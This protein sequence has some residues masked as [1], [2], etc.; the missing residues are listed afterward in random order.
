MSRNR[1]IALA[2]RE[3][4]R[5]AP[6]WAPR[7]RDPRVNMLALAFVFSFAAGC[8]IGLMLMEWALS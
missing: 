5:S 7:R 6:V 4:V 3:P 2:A 8:A 1:M